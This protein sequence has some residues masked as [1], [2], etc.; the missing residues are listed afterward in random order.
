M[1]GPLLPI[2]FW[3]RESTSNPHTHSLWLVGDFRCCRKRRDQAMRGIGENDPDCP[4][5]AWPSSSGNGPSSSTNSHPNGRRRF[6]DRPNHTR[7]FCFLRRRLSIGLFAPLP[8]FQFFHATSSA[9]SLKSRWQ[10]FLGLFFA[11]HSTPSFFGGHDFE[12]WR[13]PTYTNL[14]SP[15]NLLLTRLETTNIFSY[16]AK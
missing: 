4:C 11:P 1:R 15:R 14:T 3:R 10:C 2:V 6:N 9:F 13:W 7:S 12:T 8:A 16:M 5:V